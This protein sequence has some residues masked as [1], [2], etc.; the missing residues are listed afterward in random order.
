[1][2]KICRDASKGRLWWG[3]S[4]PPLGA[5]IL[6]TVETKNPSYRKGALIRMPLGV[7][8]RGNAG[9]LASL[10]QREVKKAIAKEVQS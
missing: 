3:Y 6:G 4:L 1:M 5:V 10:D 2:I 7:Y 8:V 9:T